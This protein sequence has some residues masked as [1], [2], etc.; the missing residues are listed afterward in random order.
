M[1]S[2][3]ENVS[4]KVKQK[5]HSYGAFVYLKKLNKKHVSKYVPLKEF[6]IS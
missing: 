6:N 1:S 3:I 2:K 4:K 5:H